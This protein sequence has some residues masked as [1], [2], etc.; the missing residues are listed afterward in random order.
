MDDDLGVPPLMDR[1][2]GYPTIQMVIWSYHI[3]IFDANI[4]EL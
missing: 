2:Y 3:V 1:P 4:W